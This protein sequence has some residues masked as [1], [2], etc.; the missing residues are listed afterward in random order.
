MAAKDRHRANIIKYLSDWDNDFPK[1]IE[2]AA[3]LG[4]KEATLW[5][6][7]TGAELDEIENEALEIRKVN[8]AR[9]RQEAYKALIGQFDKGNVPAIKEF[10][11][12]T[13]G[14][15]IER[16]ELFGKGG[17]PIEIVSAIPEPRSIKRSEKSK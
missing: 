14:K 12:R 3:I 16:R 1:R 11:E 9:P 10:L 7:F 13:E 15:V 17:G 4:V 2:F 6:I 5:A 8:A